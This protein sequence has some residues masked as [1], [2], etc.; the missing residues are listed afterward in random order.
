MVDMNRSGEEQGAYAEG[1]LLGAEASTL[2]DEGRAQEPYAHGAQQAMGK[3]SCYE[4]TIPTG[5]TLN[6]A[7]QAIFEE[8]ARELGLSNVSAQ[9]LLEIS[10]RNALAH[11]EAHKKQVLQWGED[12]RQDKELGGP[13]ME[14]TL[15]YAR[16]GLMRFDPEQKVFGMLQETGYANNPHVIRFLAAIGK[17]HAE[18][19]V[20][21]GQSASMP[22]P[23]H[24]RL[25]GKYNK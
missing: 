6:E 16:A 13:A 15:A 12:V 22:A 7:Q 17:A 19:N 9:K 5:M 8:Q 2:L 20:L 24:E 1:M 3:A 14:N 21:M 25:Y 18:D 10:H 23:R 11:R 4:L